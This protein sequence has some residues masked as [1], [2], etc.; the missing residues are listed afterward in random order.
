LY[1]TASVLGGAL[2]PALAPRFRAMLDDVLRGKDASDAYARAYRDVPPAA[3]SA[4]YRSLLTDHREY[5]QT[6]PFKAPAPPKLTTRTLSD[7]EVHALWVRLEARKGD[8]SHKTELARGLSENPGEAPLLFVK[9]SI[10][11]RAG[12]SLPTKE[13]AELR[14]IDPYDPRYVLLDLLV[15]VWPF[16]RA[17][18]VNAERDK[19]LIWEVGAL[20]NLLTRVATSPPQKALSA[21]ILSML[22]RADEARAL[23]QTVVET[24]PWCHLCLLLQGEVLLECGDPKGAIPAAEGALSLGRETDRG[25]RRET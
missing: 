7:A 22:G 13:V 17:A 9:A 3:L 21:M 18:P 14:R 25:S 20:L 23:A 15:K 24:N 4:A 5:V 10:E 12:V 8:D 11:L 6:V 2:D 19:D 1:S 16:S